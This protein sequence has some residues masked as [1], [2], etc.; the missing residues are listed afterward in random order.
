MLWTTVCLVTLLETSPTVKLEPVSWKIGI[1]DESHRDAMIER[2]GAS[3]HITSS[4]NAWWKDSVKCVWYV[5]TYIQIVIYI[6]IYVYVCRC[7]CVYVCVRVFLCWE[8]T[9]QSYMPVYEH[10][11]CSKLCTLFA[12][13]IT[14]APSIWFLFLGIIT[15]FLHFTGT[16]TASLIK[17][18]IA[19]L[20]PVGGRADA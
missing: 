6:W 9:L 20:L 7:V 18:N 8:P 3:M 11:L 2:H 5:Y 14:H 17:Y 10:T 16:M 1:L 4:S 13:L 15:G 12:N 19:G